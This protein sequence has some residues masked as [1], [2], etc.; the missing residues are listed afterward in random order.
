M[1]EESMEKP[2]EVNDNEDL[3]YVND[4]S[5]FGDPTDD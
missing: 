3:R 5:S 1:D 4:Q 2:P